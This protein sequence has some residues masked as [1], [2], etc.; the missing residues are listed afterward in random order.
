M[1]AA[2]PIV[3][4]ETTW[5]EKPAVL[6]ENAFYRL[7]IS[8]EH[9][10]RIVSWVDKDPRRPDGEFVYFTPKQG[11]LLDDRGPLTT[12]KYEYEVLRQTP[13]EIQLRLRVREGS[14]VLRDKT[15][16]CYADNRVLRV[17]YRFVN[18]AG[19]DL[20]PSVIMFKNH[21]RYS[22]GQD[23]TP[24]FESYSFYTPLTTGVRE[25]L[26]PARGHGQDYGNY[27]YTGGIAA[28]WHAQ[29][30]KNSLDGIAITLDH[31]EVDST[32]YCM[33]ESPP[34]TTFEWVMNVPQ[35][36]KDASWDTTFLYVMQRGLPGYTDV[37]DRY[38][39]YLKPVVEGRRVTFD[40]SLMPVME[41]LDL[42]EKP[43]V[44]TEIR[45]LKADAI[46]TL[47]DM[48]FPR[49]WIEEGPTAKEIETKQVAWDA[50]C[51]GTLVVWQQVVI[52]GAVAGEYELPFV[53]EEPRGEYVR[54]GLKRRPKVVEYEF[55]KADFERRYITAWR[56]RKGPVQ[57]VSV[58]ECN[59]GRNERETVQLELIPMRDIGKV[60]VAV[61]EMSGP[62][63]LPSPRVRIRQLEWGGE[64]EA[65]KY[66]LFDRTEF[67]A[68]PGRTTDI[69]VTFE[70]PSE[71]PPGDYVVELMLTPER[72]APKVVPFEIKVWPVRIA[73]RRLS[74][75]HSWWEV[76]T[77]LRETE[78]KDDAEGVRIFE[79]YAKDLAEA[80]E[81]VIHFANAEMWQSEKLDS[82]GKPVIKGG[83][84]VLDF[85]RMDPFLAVAKKYGFSDAWIGMHMAMPGLLEHLHGRGFENVYIATLDEC[86][87]NMPAEELQKWR[88]ISE[89][90]P[91]YVKRHAALSPV[92]P[93][94]INAVSSFIG[95]WSFA[96][97]LVYPVLQWQREGKTHIPPD[98]GIG[99]YGGGAHGY[100]VPYDQAIRN[101]WFAGWLDLNHWA[102]FCY[103]RS[104]PPG[105]PMRSVFVTRGG[106]ISS[107]GWEGF[108]D[109]NECFEYLR[110]IHSAARD[111]EAAGDGEKAKEV[112]E[113]LGTII[114]EG[115]DS[116]IKIRA[117]TFDG[118]ILTELDGELNDFLTAKKMVLALLTEIQQKRT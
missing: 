92:S 75:M 19:R 30:D 102:L 54:G 96:T 117:T 39:A 83:K 52:G 109:G 103:L 17:E 12:A 18:L 6:I 62:A 111:F 3:L 13:A 90:E 91:P 27:N 29:L 118:M 38:I 59:V 68:E 24:P 58:V 35:L 89:K 33:R 23:E 44:R 34:W 78:P 98:Q 94:L 51:S 76:S 99:F 16:T 14:G 80:G 36:P 57:D 8:P 9:G 37:A 101:G 97:G 41:K 15:V 77:I 56:T 48:Q 43:I 26:F 71:A 93:G 84:P 46:A 45:D 87:L 50:D 106:P 81:R 64:S 66:G 115:N 42:Q 116:P 4:G 86:P 55:D 65:E 61:S 1:P 11:G 88:G 20:D 32:Y 21:V 82:A 113:R 70:I 28:D 5:F 100:R 105:K 22:T 31:K 112:R 10:G 49:I 7:L 25:S 108:K 95:L 60:R 53:V 2:C 72:A 85:S 104:R 47:P 107:S 63:K 110:M 73:D 69:W 79:A 74:Q 40:L 67:V 114:G